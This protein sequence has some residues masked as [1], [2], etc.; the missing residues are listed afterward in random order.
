MIPDTDSEAFR[1]AYDATMGVLVAI[2][3]S[4][5]LAVVA[6]AII[7]AIVFAGIFIVSFLRRL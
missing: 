3:W 2:G 5:I 4:F 7:I 1:N 6:A